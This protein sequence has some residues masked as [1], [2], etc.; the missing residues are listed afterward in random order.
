MLSQ[1]FGSSKVYIDI[2]AVDAGADFRRKIHQAL[3]S[4]QLALVLI[5]PHWLTL[6]TDQGERRIDAKDDVVREEV[7]LA[8]ERPDVTVIPVLVEGAR[9]P[10]ASELPPEIASLEKF[11]ACDL[12]NKRWQYD[13]QQL[14]GVA[15]Q[16]DTWWGRLIFRTPR[17]VLRAAPVVALLIAVGVAVAV[18]S[19][20]GGRD[21]AQRVASC[22][23]A[24]GLAV[25]QVTRAPRSGETQFSPSDVHDSNPTFTQRTFAS[26]A[27]PPAPGA[28]G[29][30]YRTI[31]VTMTDGPSN[32]SNATGNGLSD[33]IESRCKSL[34]LTYAHEFEGAM[35][36]TPPFIAK[37]NDIW[38][39]Q[40]TPARP[41]IRTG[42]LTNEQ[43]L[44]FYAPA[45]AVVVLHGS[46]LLKTAL[47][48]A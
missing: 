5:G 20:G 37:P 6:Q 25:A 42:S 24:H 36:Q 34:Q 23:R 1:E 12:S 28:D 10:S 19:S 9:M 8:L 46:E 38:A 13:V 15:R 22:E 31:T 39:L 21:N 16:F 2:A 30:G 27:W 40:G 17:L 11:N 26:C 43:N 32:G 48:L 14:T 41:F 3:N 47:C 7:K 33:V 44:P 29:D 4:C 45:G 18:A 35:S